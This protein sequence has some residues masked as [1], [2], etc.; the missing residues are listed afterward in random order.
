MAAERAATVAAAEVGG[1]PRTEEPMPPVVMLRRLGGVG[2]RGA[3]WVMG[4]CVPMLA[5]AMA[6]AASDRATV[7]SGISSV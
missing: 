3:V 1:F 7:S 5:T 4:C 6:G 2:R